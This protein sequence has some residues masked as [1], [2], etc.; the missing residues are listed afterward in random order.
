[1]RKDEGIV[2]TVAWP[3][4]AK[5]YAEEYGIRSLIIG[6]CWTYKEK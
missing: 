2:D 1:M 4:E 5:L 6:M 3:F